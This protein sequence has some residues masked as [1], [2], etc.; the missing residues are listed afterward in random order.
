MFVE[1]E[2]GKVRPY[3]EEEDKDLKH[4]YYDRSKTKVNR[5]K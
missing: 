4:Y 3:Y 5:K 1:L 2:D